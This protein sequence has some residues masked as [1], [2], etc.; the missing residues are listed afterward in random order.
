MIHRLLSF[1]LLFVVVSLVRH[2]LLVSF[3]IIVSLLFFITMSVSKR[4]PFSLHYIW[5]FDSLSSDVDSLISSW[6]LLDG[7]VTDDLEWVFHS[8]NPFVFPKF[9]RLVTSMIDAGYNVTWDTNIPT[10]YVVER[11]W[12]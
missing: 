12:L 1:N 8:G 9:E 2:F 11:P 4:I 5:D 6:N 7:A 10:T 3:F